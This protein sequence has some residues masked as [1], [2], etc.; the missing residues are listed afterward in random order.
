MLFDGLK[1]AY[2]A[3]EQEDGEEEESETDD[4]DSEEELSSDED[5]ID[6]KGQQ[7]LEN[8]GRQ[9]LGSGG[10]AAGLNMSA[11]V[12]QD[13]DD[14]DSESDP[15][16]D[17]NEETMLESYTTPLDEKDRDMEEYIMFKEIMQSLQSS[18][19]EW[20]QTLTSNLTEHE[21]KALMEVAQLADQR[22]A[23]IESKKIKQQGGKLK[24]VFFLIYS[25]Q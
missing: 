11:N 9:V 13:D 4:G 2:A 3:R 24:N 19:P 15:D 17:P 7:Y 1:R 18:Q 12:I 6:E 5:D 21:S 22:K 20:Y 10:G 14:D 8:L 23:A 16:Y 25:C